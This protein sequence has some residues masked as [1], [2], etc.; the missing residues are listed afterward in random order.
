MPYT[1]RDQIMK[2]LR[3]PDSCFENLPDYDFEPNYKV[4]QDEDGTDIRI[5]YIDEGP[6]D[7]DPILLMHGNP[8]W[9]Y[10]YR[11]MIPELVKTGKRVIAVD[12]VGCGRSD[13]PAKRADYTLAR[14][15]DWM[16]K[17]LNAM[18]LNNISLFCQDWGGTII[19]N[20]VANQPEKFNRIIT[21]NTGLPRGMGNK[22][23]STW[24][25]VMRFAPSFPW[26]LAFKKSLLNPISEGEFKGFKAPFPKR[27]FQVGI[28]A[29]P[30]LIAIHPDNPGTAINK[31]AFEKLKQFNKPFLTLYGKQDPVSRGVDTVFQKA[32]PGAQ[33]Q[34]HARLD[35]TGHFCQ[36]DNPQ[37]LLEHIIPF[38]NA[39]NNA[40]SNDAVQS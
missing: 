26:S 11:H 16:T 5:H 6:K 8:T 14:H 12:L 25:K 23:L 17:W 4:I 34:P 28:L 18:E 29:F 1:G 35:N 33:G 21:S 2:I 30:Q 27:K 24:L 22:W 36:E 3:T 32:I 19:L 7:A 15:I 9:S 31:A 20:I 37:K 10:L 40:D 39:K 38:F 13:K